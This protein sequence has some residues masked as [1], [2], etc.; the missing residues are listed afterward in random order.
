MKSKS[1]RCGIL[2]EL[3]AGSEMPK[4]KVYIND[5][6]I[7]EARTWSQVFALIPRQGLLLV[8]KPGAAEGP[9][10]FYVSGSIA[11]RSS[12]EATERKA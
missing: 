4:K 8:G 3:A 6:L 2:L 7:G 1:T 10:G 5:Q 12:I 11:R 9:S